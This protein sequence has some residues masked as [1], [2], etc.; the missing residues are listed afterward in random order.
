MKATKLRGTRQDQAA[1]NSPAAA[2]ITGK[3][4]GKK[5]RYFPLLDLPN[6]GTAVETLGRLSEV[7]DTDGR[8]TW[9]SAQTLADGGGISV[10][11]FHRHFAKLKDEKR[12]ATARRRGRSSLKLLT[13]HVTQLRK[14][15]HWQLPTSVDDQRLSWPAKRVLAYVVRTVG[16]TKQLTQSAADIAQLLGMG[17]RSV[18]LALATLHKRGVVDR[19]RKGQEWVTQLLVD[20]PAKA[21]ARVAPSTPAAD[22]RRPIVA[23]TPQKRVFS[24]KSTVL[25]SEAQFLAHKPKRYTP[26]CAGLTL[27]HYAK[28]NRG[29]NTLKPRFFDQLPGISGVSRKTKLKKRIGSKKSPNSDPL[30]CKIPAELTEL[31]QWCVWR[32]DQGRKIPHQADG[33]AA[34][35]NDPGTWTTFA[36]AMKAAPRFSGPGFVFCESDGLVGIDLD[37]CRNPETGE[38]SGWAAE[39]I[40]KIDSYSEVSPSGTGIKVFVRADWCGKGRKTQVDAEKTGE[41]APGIEIYATRRYFCV[42]GERLEGV[43]A[44]VEERTPE[45]AQLL[46]EFWPE[47]E[48]MPPAQRP[49]LPRFGSERAAAAYLA[50][51]PPAVSGQRGHDATYH[52]SCVAVQRFGLGENEALGVLQ[53]WNETCQPPWSDRELL[54]KIHDAQKQPTESPHR[55]AIGVK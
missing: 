30:G 23:A 26:R 50:K 52:A 1:K 43:S 16:E 4:A 29:A 44:N 38:I 51:V 54:H 46:A 11:T 40:R 5:F 37:G 7:I 45:V 3:T 17:T 33:T 47:P 25:K 19:W 22:D 48:W 20:A 49:G 31:P 9:K 21:P 35:T 28:F 12:V 14:E 6:L 13:S 10:R 41:K 39:I 32:S 36:Q 53:T 24:R 2:P 27:E 34:K 15:K 8:S 18:Q 55:E 42:T